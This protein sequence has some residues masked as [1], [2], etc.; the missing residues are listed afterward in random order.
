MGWAEDDGLA[1]LPPM[2]WRSW[3]AF[4]NDISDTVIRAQIDGITSRSREIDGLGPASLFDVGY[5]TVGIDEGWEGCGQGVNGTQH[6]INGLPVIDTKKFP[7][8]AGT[9]AHGHKKNLAMGF[10]YNGCACGERV[11]LVKNYVGDVLVHEQ[12]GFDAVKLDSCGA[13]KNLTRYHALY[14][15]TAKRPVLI[16]NCH[17]GHEFP[18]GGNP[19][20]DGWCPY[21]LFRTSGDIVNLWDRV[22]SNLQSTR[23]FRE[24]GKGPA[25][26]T[27]SRPGCWAYPDMLEVGRM[28]GE[29]GFD[30]EILAT[31]LAESRSHFGAWAISSSPLVLGLSLDAGDAKAMAALD[32]VWDVITNREVIAV[33]QTWA[34]LPGAL[35]REWQA[36]NV[37]TLVA[38]PCPT[39]PTNQEDFIAS[40]ANLTHWTLDEGALRQ[41]D[42]DLCVD[43]AGQLPLLPDGAANW[44]RLRACDKAQPGQ[45]WLLRASGQLESKAKAGQCI[46]FAEHWLWNYK[47]VPSLT[48]CRDDTAQV[49]AFNSKDGTLRVPS[50]KLCIGSSDVSGPASQ[51]WRKPLSDGKTAVLVINGALLA[52][53]TVQV[54]LEELGLHGAAHVRDIWAK[55]DIG[56]VDT[57]LTI[58]LAPHDSAMFLLSPVH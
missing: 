48:S 11:E 37:P 18:D 17:Q 3:N 23:S 13:Q 42:T 12:L 25:N 30:G 55:K 26:G 31:S 44:M 15:S 35:V 9:V 21:H 58:E 41:T 39:S 27:L 7:D 52:Q 2:S 34:G 22:L 47:T 4:H 45:L 43:S 54:T 33:S 28:P 46:S 1:L 32:E 6:D 50:K 16:E 29:V 10:Y 36:P 24:P 5:N 20:A 14:N 38:A 53:K 51:V 57:A 56:V 19:R 40:V 49:F 8:L